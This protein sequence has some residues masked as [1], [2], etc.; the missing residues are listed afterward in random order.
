MSLSRGEVVEVK[1]GA[2][3]RDLMEE[4]G[5][6]RLRVATDLDLHFPENSEMHEMAGNWLLETTEG[7]S[8]KGRC[9]RPLMRSLFADEAVFEDEEGVIGIS[10]DA[11]RART[12]KSGTM[13]H[14][15]AGPATE[16]GRGKCAMTEI[17][18]A[19]LR[20]TGEKTTFEGNGRNAKEMIVSEESNR[21]VRTPETRQVDNK[22]PSH[23]VLL[24]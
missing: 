17:V 20:P 18:N 4:I 1:N 10:I 9:K 3:E 21:F 16:T 15:G 2:P 5:D 22:R 7:I 12:L 8:E 13:L 11:E 23:L 24:Q 14:P 6:L 19:I